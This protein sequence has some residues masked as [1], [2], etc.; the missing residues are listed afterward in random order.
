MNTIANVLGSSALPTAPEVKAPVSER[1]FDV[2]EFQSK[3]SQLQSALLEAHPSMPV[4]L[5]EIH[6]QIRK[7]PELVTIISEEEIGVIVN[8]LKKQTNTEIAAKTTKTTKTTMKKQV[9][10]VSL[11]DI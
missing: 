9:A 2:L 4:L 10:N 3:I 1:E 7:D 6:N 8:G 11:D 5:R